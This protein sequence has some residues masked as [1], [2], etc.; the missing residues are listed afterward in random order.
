MPLF[1]DALRFDLWP[2]DTSAPATNEFAAW[3]DNDMARC[4]INRHQGFV[5]CAFADASGRKVALKELW[6]LKWSKS[7]NPRGRWTRAGN[8]DDNQWPEWIRPL[9]DF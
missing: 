5:G 4:C 6:T 9:K 8:V 1:I 3:T 2:L 7:F